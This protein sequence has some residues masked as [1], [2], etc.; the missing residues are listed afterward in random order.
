MSTNNTEIMQ[1]NRRINNDFAEAAALLGDHFKR[2]Y[3]LPVKNNFDEKREICRKNPSPQVNL[4]KAI[5][6]F[7]KNSDIL[8]NMIEMMI[9]YDA[10]TKMIKERPNKVLKNN[11]DEQAVNSNGKNIFQEKMYFDQNGMVLA[12]LVIIFLNR[13]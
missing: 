9:K 7:T 13:I 10:V 3:V 5:L 8:E 2:K 12:L 11:V 6:P 4:M 1:S